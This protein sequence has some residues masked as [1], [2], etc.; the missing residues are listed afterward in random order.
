MKKEHETTAQWWERVSNDPVEMDKW[1]QNQYYGEVTAANRIRESVAK[2]NLKGLKAKIIESIA[3]DEEKHA[4]WVSR[5][6]RARMIECV[7]LEKAERYWKETLPKELEVNT[8]KYFCAVGHLAEVMR[9]DRISLI[10]S[11]ER[12]SDIAEVMRK[13][14]DDEVFHARMFR[15]ISSQK[16]ISKARKYHNMGMNAIGLLP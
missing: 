15:E 9:L 6:L 5:L 3:K 14:Y 7:P 4:V 8:F 10:A 11:D 1:L 13:I 12:F 16:N 2:Y